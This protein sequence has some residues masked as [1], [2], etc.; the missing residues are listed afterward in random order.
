[1]PLG[2]NAMVQSKAYDI[3]HQLVAASAI[4][5]VGFTGYLMWQANC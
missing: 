3:S 4:K 5:A 2:V 1:M